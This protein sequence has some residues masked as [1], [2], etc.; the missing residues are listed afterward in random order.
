MLVKVYK[1]T[2]NPKKVVKTLGTPIQIDATIK[3]PLEIINPVFYVNYNSSILDCNY[4]E[5]NGRFFFMNSEVEPGGAMRLQCSE[6]FLM[7]WKGG[8]VSNPGILESPCICS[9]NENSYDSAFPDPRY[10]TLQRKMI[11]TKSLFTL[12]NDDSI[13][14]AFI[15]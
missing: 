3:D 1:N 6:D 4:L 15:E 5:A 14:F 10:P 12:G 9:R 11:E 7:S 2:E 13:I 8:S